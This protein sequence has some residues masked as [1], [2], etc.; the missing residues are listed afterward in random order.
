[1][2]STAIQVENLAYI[3]AA[4]RLR[5][6]LDKAGDL[7]TLSMLNERL[8][9]TTEALLAPFLPDEA[10]VNTALTHN[11]DIGRLAYK[12][13]VSTKR[14][15][16]TDAIEVRDVLRHTRRS[17]LWRLANQN[18][19]A[20][21]AQVLHMYVQEVCPGALSI[22]NV[23]DPND[24]G[25]S[26]VLWLPDAVV[27]TDSSAADGESVP[28]GTATSPVGGGM[29]VGSCTF[30][31]V[32][33]EENGAELELARFSSV[34]VADLDRMQHAQHVVAC[35]VADGLLDR[36][37]GCS[38]SL[39]SAARAIGMQQQYLAFPDK[40]GY[41]GSRGQLLP[42]WR[43]RWFVLHHGTL[44]YWKG[45]PPFHPL[46]WSVDE[47]RQHTS[48][49]VIPLAGGSLTVRSGDHGDRWSDDRS[50]SARTST[51][52]APDEARS[53]FKVSD[54]AMPCNDHVTEVD[55]PVADS[56]HAQVH[57]GA[58]S[59]ALMDAAATMTAGDKALSE[60]VVQPV[61]QPPELPVHI[62]C[63]ESNLNEIEISTPCARHP[64]YFLRAE[65]AAEAWAWA[66]A[67]EK[68]MWPLE[69]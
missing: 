4:R 36:N 32:T 16:V 5:A 23:K 53:R 59:E 33:Q 13:H 52:E 7:E 1:M 62:V 11:A 51:R 35:T 42:I 56:S 6:W 43:K 3:D 30:R 46:E 22:S 54:T 49:D 2:F 68:H 34:V 19:F 28:L 29:L 21:I 37:D 10:Q 64:K 55:A 61:V 26:Y 69:A 47:L 38:S 8:L 39:L 12:V 31:V 27:D 65:S 9:E 17:L 50:Q 41:L 18:L 20:T 57:V 63:Q 14:D 24:Q 45:A 67:I 48:V 25:G 44:R 15:P 60:H 66:V 40:V 58:Q